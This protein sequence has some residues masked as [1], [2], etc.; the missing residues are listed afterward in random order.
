M[1]SPHKAGLLQAYLGSLPSNLAVRLAKAVE[2]DR[3]TDGALLPHELILEGLRPILSRGQRD[4]TPTPL[5]LFC[6]P[7]EDMLTSAPR[8]VKQKGRIARSSIMPVWNWVTEE[9]IPKASDAYISELKSLLVSFRADEARARAAAFWTDAAAAMREAFEIEGGRKKVERMF[10]DEFIAADAYEMALLLAGGAEILRLQETLPSPVQAFTPE[11]IAAARAIYDRLVATVPDAAPYVVVVTMNRL[12]RPW[13]ALR[14][15]VLISRKSGDTL[16]ASTDMGMAGDLLFA[17]L[18]ALSHA[19]RSARH[20][21]FDAEA[22]VEDVASFAELSSGIVKELELRR[23]G[24]WGQSLLKDRAEIGEVMN[25]FMRRAP[26]EIANAF[27]TKKHVKTMDSEKVE[28]ALRYAT[29]IAGCRPFAAAA[30]FAASLKDAQDEIVGGLRNINDD[31]LWQLR[32]VEEAR[33][34]IVQDQFALATELT[35]ILCGDAE[36]EVL[37]RRGRAARPAAA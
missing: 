15:A 2:V 7:F 28:R 1:L 37:R 3:L 23:D 22:L 4:R 31:L 33:R 24:R 25:G 10:K 12:A 21:R 34:Q 5:R 13:E 29:L 20:P 19:I 26:K 30:S 27:P 32:A 14:L 9:L 16:I 17:D 18:E 36:A 35:S 6:R 11:L 8:G